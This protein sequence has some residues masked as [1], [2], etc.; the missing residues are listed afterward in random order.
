M[1]LFPLVLA[2]M[3]VGYLP[4]D[5]RRVVQVARAASMFTAADE[6]KATHKGLGL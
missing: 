4:G 3:A 2:H 6:G 1:D 5:L